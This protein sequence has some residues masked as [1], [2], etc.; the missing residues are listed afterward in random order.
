MKVFFDTN[1]YIAEALLGRAAERMIRA[2]LR[3]KWRTYTS[4]DVLSEVER[5]M[6][7]LRFPRRLG[8]LS[9]RRIARRTTNVHAPSSRHRVPGDPHDSPILHAAVHCGADYLVTND[10]HLLALDPYETLRIVS[11]D[12]YL[13]IL[14]EHGML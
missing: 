9:R 10:R 12:R 13:E 8:A 14:R 7:R 2:T 11:M 1:V 4:A 5:V 3:A 6:V